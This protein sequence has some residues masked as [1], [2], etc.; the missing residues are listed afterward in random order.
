MNQFYCIILLSELGKKL[1]RYKVLKMFLRVKL[2][3]KVKF[4]L[5][6]ALT[7]IITMGLDAS[8]YQNVLNGKSSNL[9][10]R[11]FW[12]CLCVYVIFFKNLP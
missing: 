4:D 12:P 3:Y 1:I 11:T 10:N 7:E 5:P 2:W 8:V 6:K 9:I